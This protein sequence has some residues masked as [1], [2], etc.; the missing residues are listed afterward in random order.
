ME[1]LIEEVEGL[2]G[3]DR[4][5]VS[6]QLYRLLK[7][8]VKQQMQPEWRGR[9]W[10]QSI[11]NAQN[12]IFS[13]IDR[14]PSLRRF[15]EEEVEKVYARAVRH[16]LVETGLKARKDILGIP[17]QCPWSFEERLEGDANN[18]NWE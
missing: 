3:S 15:V 5:A 4:S 1:H 8:L 11:T 7:H 10:T 2:A 14:S 9:S 17:E 18:L 13:R 16:A 12:R 6:S